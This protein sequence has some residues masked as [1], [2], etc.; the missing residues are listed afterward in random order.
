MFNDNMGTYPGKLSTYFSL[1]TVLAPEINDQ[2][3][4]TI[5]LIAPLSVTTEQKKL[6]IC[7]L[8]SKQ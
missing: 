4:K 3:L 6:E 5:K 2:K 7:K 8:Y 1:P